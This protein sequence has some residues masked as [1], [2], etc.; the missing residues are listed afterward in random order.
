MVID[1]PP[2]EGV[3]DQRQV[4]VGI[5]VAEHAHQ[6]HLR[7][8]AHETGT[9]EM[10][11]RLDARVVDQTDELFETSRVASLANGGRVGD[12]GQLPGTDAVPRRTG[13]ART[14]P[15]S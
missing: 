2:L 5:D 8:P 11:R 15:C 13:R 3:A 12:A 7:D 9:D 10:T 14:T 4:T 6:T 1:A